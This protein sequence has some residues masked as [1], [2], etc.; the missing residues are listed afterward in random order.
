MKY[1]IETGKRSQLTL[2]GRLVGAALFLLLGVAMVFVDINPDWMNWVLGLV[3]FTGMGVILLWSAETSDEIEAEDVIEVARQAIY[4]EA[5]RLDGKRANLER[6]LMAY[7][8][9]MEFPDFE[10]LQEVHWDS[11][12]QIKDE[13]I[14]K[15]LSDQSD[16]MLQAFSDGSF[17]EDGKFQSRKM[18]MELF[19]F[20]EEIA[21]IYN[22]DAE[23][24]ILETNLESF[25]KAINRASLQIILLLEELPVLDVKDMNIRKATDSIRKA[26]NVYKKYEEIQPILQ[27]MRYLW[28]GGK[29][30]LS[31]NPL[32]AAGWIAGSELLWKGGKKLGKK[33]MD[34]YLL[35]LVRQTL[36]II[37]WETAGIYDKTYRYRNPDWIYGLEI[38][39]LVSKFD[40]TTELLRSVFKEL[41]GLPLRSSYDRIF[42]YRCVANHVSP[43]PERFSAFEWMP[44]EV[45]NEINDRLTKFSETNLNEE[46]RGSTRFGKWR[47]EMQARIGSTTNREAELID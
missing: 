14:T 3:S 44:T 22:P 34:A 35:S 31:S 38:V 40:P 11:D 24:P 28:Q 4:N 25:L 42:L 9:W 7:G 17:Y 19:N 18:I 46:Q 1:K 29:F 16:R 8:D 10:K 32:V 45:A 30:F 20:M 13:R 36:G 47:S 15:I 43:K 26:S 27:P 41:G 37:A 39:H 12:Q 33:A 23:K 2:G 5:E 21:R 6:V